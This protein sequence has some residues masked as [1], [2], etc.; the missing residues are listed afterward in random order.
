AG[1]DGAPARPPFPPCLA[2]TGTRHLSRA[3]IPGALFSFRA[4]VL[5]RYAQFKPH[6]RVVDNAVR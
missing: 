2:G 3:R 1:A 6:D 4:V 5:N